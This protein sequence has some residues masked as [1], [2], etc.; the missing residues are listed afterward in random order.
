MKIFIFGECVEIEDKFLSISDMDEDFQKAHREAVDKLLY[1]Y[2]KP[3]TCK[4]GE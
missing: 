3:L 2:E 4:D 1:N